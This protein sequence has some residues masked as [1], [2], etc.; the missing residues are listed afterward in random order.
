MLTNNIFNMN[1]YFGVRNR[2]GSKQIG[3]A[4]VFSFRYEKVAKL[5]SLF[6][7]P[8]LVLII[9]DLDSN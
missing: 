9:N 2:Q 6:R 8:Y 1:V 7:V 4:S 3:C 5:K